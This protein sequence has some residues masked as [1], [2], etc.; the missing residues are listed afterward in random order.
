[1]N[2]L[3]SRTSI[4]R[5]EHDDFRETHFRWRGWRWE[6]DHKQANQN[7]EQTAWDSKLNTNLFSLNTL[8]KSDKP[9]ALPAPDTAWTSTYR[10][11]TPGLIARTTQ[12]PAA[13]TCTMRSK[14]PAAVR[15]TCD[16]ASPCGTVRV[17]EPGIKQMSNQM[18]GVENPRAHVHRRPSRS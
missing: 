17:C 5:Y 13:Q 7:A 6:N 3:I 16:S 11:C 8:S 10:A 14:S 4:S 18:A 2:D 15:G 12:Q 1:M 9:D